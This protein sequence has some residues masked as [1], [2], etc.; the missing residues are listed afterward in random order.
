MVFSAVIHRVRGALETLSTDCP[1]EEVVGLCPELSWTQVFLAVDY[2]SQ[3]GEVQVLL[4]SGRA[5]RV[6]VNHST[7]SGAGHVSAN[8]RTVPIVAGESLGECSGAMQK[9][10]RTR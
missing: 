6:Q 10:R 7:V 9:E 4:D 5:Y 3:T 1:V 8:H 2:L